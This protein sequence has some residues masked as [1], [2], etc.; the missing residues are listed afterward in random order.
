MHYSNPFSTCE[1][2]KKVKKGFNM[3]FFVPKGNKDA[4]HSKKAQAPFG[5]SLCLF[6]I[7]FSCIAPFQAALKT[8]DSHFRIVFHTAAI[9]LQR[10]CAAGFA[11]SSAAALWSIRLQ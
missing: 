11:S 1:N 4:V 5:K 10:L 3:L 2:R 6:A 7:W 8:A 9:R